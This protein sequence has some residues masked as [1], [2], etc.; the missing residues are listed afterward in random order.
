MQTRNLANMHTQLPTKF[1]NL[2]NLKFMLMN[3]ILHMYI[4]ILHKIYKII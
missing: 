2:Q 3:L 1:Q 4:Y